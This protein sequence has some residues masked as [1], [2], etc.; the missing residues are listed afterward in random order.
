MD[1]TGSKMSRNIVV[2]SVAKDLVKKIMF[3]K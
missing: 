3:K 2:L 1:R